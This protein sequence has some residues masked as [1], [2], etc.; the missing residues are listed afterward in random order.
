MTCYKHLIRQILTSSLLVAP[1][2]TYGAGS[3]KFTVELS[4]A[5]SFVAQSYSLAVQGEAK[6]TLDGVQAKH[7]SIDLNSFRTGIDLRD[8]HLKEKYFETKKYPNAVLTHAEGKNGKFTG[9]LDLHGVKKAVEGVYQIK[10]GMFLGR[11]KTKIS[12]YNIAPA[13]YMGV[14]VEDDVE[15]EIS[16]PETQKTSR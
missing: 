16:L 9:E 8:R 7:I 12:D 10:G 13:K 4:P 2:L 15:V 14:G 3:A 11:F 6:R 5:G 1:S